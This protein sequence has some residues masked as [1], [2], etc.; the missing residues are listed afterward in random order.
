MYRPI[1]WFHLVAYPANFLLQFYSV[2]V[3]NVYA[4]GI[5]IGGLV[6]VLFVGASRFRKLLFKSSEIAPRLP[7]TALRLDDVTLFF[8]PRLESILPLRTT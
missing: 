8:R 4:E 2:I 7:D 3:P 5:L 6:H 1:F